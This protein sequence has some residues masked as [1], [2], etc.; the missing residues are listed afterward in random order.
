MNRTISL[1]AL[2]LLLLALVACAGAPSATPVPAATL[3]PTQMPATAIPSPVPTQPPPPATRL[4]SPTSAPKPTTAQTPA[5]AP[6]VPA[7]AF[8]QIGG[9]LNRDAAAA[10]AAAALTVGAQDPSKPGVSWVAWSEKQGNAQQIFVS[11]QNGIAFEPV[12]ASLN[13]HSN[14]VADGPS[15]TFAGQDHTVPWVAWFEPSPDFA[16]K[17]NVFASRFNAASGL[18]VP[19]G[20]DRGNNEPS[21]NIHTNQLAQDP[22]IVAG[23]ADPA[24]PPVP[25]VCWQEVSAHNNAVEVF[26]SR[27]ISDPTALGGFKFQPVGLNRSG[28]ANDPEPSVNLDVTGGSNSSHCQITFAETNNT[29]PWVVWAEKL[30][31]SPTMIFVARAVTDSTAGA[32]GFKWE[33]V[34]NCA[35]QNA[36]QCALNVNP[37]KEGIDPSIAAGTVLP[38]QATVPWIVWDEVGPNGKRQIFVNRLDQVSRRSFINVGSSL[39]ADANRD[40]GNPSITFV[41]NVPYVIWD[42]EVGGTRRLFVRHLASDPQTG[43]WALDTPPDGIAVDRSRIA[44]NPT[45]RATPDGKVVIAFIEGDPAKEASQVIVC[46]NAT[47]TSSLFRFPGLAAP[48]PLAATC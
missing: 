26:V 47:L 16:N 39:N 14:V 9:S 29:V 19:A 27:A 35:A 5:Q 30:R 18:W 46:T 7:A 22:D 12:G 41:G 24:K 11:K 15:I 10:A 17:K 20:Q 3:V 34:P 2:A 40:A 37:T 23:S 38:G 44:S 21:L 13:I 4:P 42:E 36:S 33:F 43:T 48:F 1:A 8:R 45:I 6:L 32:G 25:W 31:L 28:A